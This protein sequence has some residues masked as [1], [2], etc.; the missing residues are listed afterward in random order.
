[1]SSKVAQRRLRLA[2]HCVRH[3]EEIANKLVLWQPTEGR[4]NR[5]R[6][7]V[8][9]IDNLKSDTGLE[10]ISEIKTVMMDRVRWKEYV[11]VART[12]ARPR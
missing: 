8:N 1:M 10:D 6:R 7:P 11:T 12:G 4:A 3:E 2:G 5:G 9:Y